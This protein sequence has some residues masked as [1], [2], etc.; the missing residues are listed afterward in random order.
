M[1]ASKDEDPLPAPATATAPKPEQPATRKKALLGEVFA[2]AAKRAMGGGIAGALAMVVQVLAL[3]WLRTT[4]NF[5]HSKGLSTF[6]AMHALYEQGGIPRFY[7]GMWFALLQAPLSRFGDT[8]A[9]AGMLALLEDVDWMAPASKTLCA[10]LAAALFRIFLCPID[11]LK[12]TLQV[13]GAEG[14]AVLRRRV[15]SQGLS[16]LYA[17]ALGSSA[18][19]LVG[20]YPWFLTHNYL[21]ARIPKAAGAARQIRSAAIGLAS[22]FNSDVI[23]NSVRVVKTAKQTHP[24]GISYLATIQMIIAADGVSGLMFRGLGTKILSNGVQ[25]MLFTVCWK[26]LERVIAAALAPKPTEAELKPVK[27]E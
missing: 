25:A 24:D 16:T 6:E 27:A 22:S 19:T 4:I 20:H 9:N 3:M 21:D 26:Y 17:G 18:A 23:S 13:Q 11:T 14:M 5:Q 12:T 10:S 8:A 1:A 15:T 7:R 2:R